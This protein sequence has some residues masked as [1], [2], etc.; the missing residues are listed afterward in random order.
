MTSQFIGTVMYV[1]NF[2]TCLL[3]NSIDLVDGMS[4]QFK[5]LRK[6]TDIGIHA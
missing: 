1:G 2:D 6:I 5:I 3:I 4:G